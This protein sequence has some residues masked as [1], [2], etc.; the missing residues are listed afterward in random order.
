MPARVDKG[1]VVDDDVVFVT[2]VPIAVQAFQRTVL[3]YDAD[4]PAGFLVERANAGTDFQRVF[5][6]QVSEE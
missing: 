2:D 3:T 6:G 4:N 5:P 1:R